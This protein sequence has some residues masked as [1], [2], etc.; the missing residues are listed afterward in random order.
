MVVV[1][2]VMV[3]ARAMFKSVASFHFVICVVGVPF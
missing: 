3:A 2:T 1:I